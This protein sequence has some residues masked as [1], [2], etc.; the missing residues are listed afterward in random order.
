VRRLAWWVVRHP[1]P[2]IGGWLV[3]VLALVGL[4]QAAGGPVYTN[5]FSFSGYG[6]QRAQTLLQQ[7]FPQA[8]G[9]QDQ[10]VVHTT[11]GRVTDPAVRAR[12]EP[13]LARVT[14]LPHV[15]AVASPYRRASGAVSRDGRTAFATVTFDAPADDLPDAA[16]TAVMDRA[17]AAAT[18]TLQVALL[19]QAIEQTESA[20]PGRA[21]FVGLAAAMVVLLLLFGSVVSMLLPILTV[22]LAIGAGINVDGLVSHLMPLSSATLAIALMIAL[23]VGIDYSLFIVSRFRSLLAEGRTPASAAVG[24]VD[25]SGRA[26]LFAG[27]IVVLALLGMLLLGVSITDGIAIG[28]A[29]AVAFTIAAAL[30]L[31]PALLCLLGPRVN[32]LRIP[33]RHLGGT[34]GVTARFDAW[35]RLVRRARWPLAATVVVVL[36]VLAVPL[37]GL[38]LGQPDAGADPPASTTHQAYRLLAD[39]FGPGFTGPLLLAASLPAPGGTGAG[40]V[41][42]LAGLVQA[43]PGV[44]SIVPPRVNPA[45]TTAVMEVYPTT[46]PEAA[47]TAALVHRLRRVIAQGTA[48]TGVDVYVGGPTATYIDLSSL[49]A[50]RLLPFIVLVLG[51]GF[52]LLLVVFRSLAIPITAAVMNLLSIG[53]AL[54]VIVAVF[55]KGW[56][57]LTPGPVDF[58][59]PTMMFAIVFGL[60]TD[61]QV[62]L[63]TRVQEQWHR[64]RDTDRAVHEGMGRVSGIITGAAVIMIAVFCSFVVGGQLLLQQIGLGFAVAVALDAFLIRFLLVP[65]VMYILGDRNWQFPR[66]LQWMPRVHVEPAGATD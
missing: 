19:G 65:A 57:G 66:W 26:V 50:S 49:L 58:A 39:G 59:V 62:F 51:I 27:S 55:Q 47:A 20:G 40:V 5:R 18:P 64:H 37:L 1:W 8:G 3:V 42:R 24:A 21:T 61:Y 4:S 30:T 14:R 31:L 6:S 52:V 11:A 44:A 36:A 60:S 12:L 29:V 53:A 38:R 17:R 13:V 9:D 63:L 33:G 46:S 56:T 48:G 2:V 23:G 22:L 32:R 41:D 7:H 15:V 54:G 45:G 25:T 16:V 34:V 28:A 43:Q 35:A 10:I